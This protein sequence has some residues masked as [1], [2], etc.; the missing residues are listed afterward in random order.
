LLV[1]GV[2]D[3][4]LSGGR[5]APIL[6]IIL[7]ELV[8]GKEAQGL[9]EGDLVDDAVDGGGVGGGVDRLL[10]LPMVVDLLEDEKPVKVGDFQAHDV[11]GV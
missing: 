7:V 2:D 3:H 5:E 10:D 4:P 6:Q 8:R 11:V 9:G 1:L